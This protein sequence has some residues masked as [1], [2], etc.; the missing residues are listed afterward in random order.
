MGRYQKKKV[1]HKRPPAPFKSNFEHTVSQAIEFG[2]V[3]PT[4]EPLKLEYILTKHYTPDFMIPRKDGTI[5]YVESKGYFDSDSREKM[6]AVKTQHPGL[7]IVLLFMDDKFINKKS[8]F[9]YTIW[10]Q[11]HGFD[12]SVG[13]I[14][15]RWI[16]GSELP[17]KLE[18]KEILLDG[19]YS[20]LFSPE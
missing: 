13:S 9:S 6:L 20:N 16:Y 17:K 12:Y 14:P 7:E 11:K 8:G 5:L 4:Y 1:L 10:A 3:T 2:G 19:N 18:N 15:Y